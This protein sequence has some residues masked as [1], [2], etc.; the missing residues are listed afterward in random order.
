MNN[1]NISLIVFKVFLSKKRK[2]LYNY[3]KRILSYKRKINTNVSIKKK[4]YS[5]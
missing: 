2:Y 3:N 1:T 5:G 4:Y